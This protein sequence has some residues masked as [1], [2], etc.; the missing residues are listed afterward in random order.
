MHREVG[1]AMIYLQIP[2]HFFQVKAVDPDIGRNGL[3]RYE[4]KKDNKTLDT[5][6][7]FRVSPTSGEITVAASPLQVGRRS[8]FIEAADQPENPS[9]RRLSLALVSVEITLS[10]EPRKFYYI[11]KQLLTF[12]MMCSLFQLSQQ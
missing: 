9:E 8:L 10:G 6:S 1:E 4:L 5:P 2:K 7:M 12:K 11:P 3:V